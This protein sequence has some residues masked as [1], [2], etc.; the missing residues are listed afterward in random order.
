MDGLAQDTSN[1]SCD[2]RNEVTTEQFHYMRSHAFA[3]IES[4]IINLA[5]MQWNAYCLECFWFALIVCMEKKALTSHQQ[6]TIFLPVGKTHG[7]DS[8]HNARRPASVG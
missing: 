8:I 2:L 5:R 4:S 1:V 3:W 7:A 6:S